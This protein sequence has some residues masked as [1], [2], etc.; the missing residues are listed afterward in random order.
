MAACIAWNIRGNGGI[1]IQQ[2]MFEPGVLR[3]QR[4]LTAVAADVKNSLRWHRDNDITAS[5]TIEVA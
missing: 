3:R 1:D 2:H 4:D 5:S